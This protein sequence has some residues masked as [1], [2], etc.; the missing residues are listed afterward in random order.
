MKKYCITYLYAE[1]ESRNARAC[2]Q[3]LKRAAKELGVSLRLKKDTTG[4]QLITNSIQFPEGTSEEFK[5]RAIP[6]LLKGYRSW[7]KKWVLK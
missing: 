4:I 7:Y 1:C 5:D 6:L 3:G 2:L